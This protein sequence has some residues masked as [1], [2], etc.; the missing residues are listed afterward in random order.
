M[1]FLSWGADYP[2]PD[3][4]LRVGLQ[5]SQSGWRH[6]AYYQ[7]VH[8]ARRVT[9]QDVRLEMYQQADRILME[10]APVMATTY[11]RCQLLV[12]PW[13][14]RHPF[15]ATKFWFWKDVVIEPH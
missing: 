7:L 9:E 2:D 6:E 10:E 13:V 5:S 4:F 8:D 1:W 3:T 12:K 15:S 11:G 14:K